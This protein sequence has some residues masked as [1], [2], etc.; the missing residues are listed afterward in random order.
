MLAT[1]PHRFCMDLW[2]LLTG[3]TGKRGPL[4]QKNKPRLRENWGFR[5][6]GEIVL[7]GDH[8]GSTNR[9]CTLCLLGHIVF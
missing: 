1:N 8:R 5:L 6:I 7:F 9:R 3:F 4:L 2:G